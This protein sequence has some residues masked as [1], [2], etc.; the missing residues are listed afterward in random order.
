MDDERPPQP[1]PA[2]PRSSRQMAIRPAGRTL[3]PSAASEGRG[4]S[5]ASKVFAILEAFSPG[6]ASLSL[7][8]ISRRTGLPIATAHRLAMELVRLGG[9]ERDRGNK[10]RVGVRLWEIGSLAPE[11]GGL[12]ELAKPFLEDR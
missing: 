12:R 9:L 6:E 3:R 7:T 10:Y 1:D 11:R 5:V 8:R 2:T 4:P